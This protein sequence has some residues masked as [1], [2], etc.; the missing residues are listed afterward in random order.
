MLGT[1]QTRSHP[2]SQTP[3][4]CDSFVGT[5]KVHKKTQDLEFWIRDAQLIKP[6]QVFQN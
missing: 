4:L 1:I 6:M 3:K 5:H 2:S